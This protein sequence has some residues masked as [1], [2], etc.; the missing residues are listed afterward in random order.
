MDAGELREFA[1]RYFEAWNAHDPAAVGGCVKDDVLWED[2]ALPQPARGRT[3]VEAFV[4]LTR[5]AFPDYEFSETGDPSVSEDGLT[6]YAPW[7]MT[8]TNTGAIDPPGFAA[9]GRRIEIEGIDRWQFRDGLISRYR[10]FYDFTEMARQLG[11]MP[12]RG[13]ALE[14]LGARAQR[15][16][17]KVRR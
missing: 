4:Q 11:L 16:A 8:G 3:E 12:A 9:T 15:L 14:R 10:A 7:R 13:G 1:V 5:T 6:A 2:P 17:A